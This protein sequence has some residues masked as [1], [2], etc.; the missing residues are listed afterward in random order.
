MYS[1]LHMNRTKDAGKYFK[2]H[3]KSSCP[4]VFCKKGVPKNFVKFTEKHL[5]QSLFFNKVPGLRPA[6]LLKEETLAQVFSYGFY[7]NFKNTFFIEHFWWLL[8]IIAI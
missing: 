8:L 4:E 2:Y 5:R 6:T 1:Q 3:S 7:K